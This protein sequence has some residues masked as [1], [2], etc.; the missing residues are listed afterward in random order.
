MHRPACRE[1][2]GTLRKQFKMRVCLVTIILS[3]HCGQGRVERMP[4]KSDEHDCCTELNLTPARRAS[5]IPRNMQSAP[6]AQ[7]LDA[8]GSEAVISLII[9]DPPS[10][11]GV[12]VD[13]IFTWQHQKKS[14]VPKGETRTD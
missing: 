2:A 12:R 14:D 11:A 5:G 9:S 7:A 8:E 6:L 3:T 10:H 4:R 1:L 13:N